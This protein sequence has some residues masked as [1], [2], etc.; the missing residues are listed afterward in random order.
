MRRRCGRMRGNMKEQKNTLRN[1]GRPIKE[2]EI[3]DLDLEESIG[4]GQ[5]TPYEEDDFPE[6][7]P[8]NTASRPM[9][10]RSFRINMHIVFAL[11]FVAII[12]AVILRVSNWGVHIDLE[13]FFKHNEVVYQ[14][15]TL[16]QILPLTAADGTVIRGKKNPTI[17]CLGNAPFADERDSR[18][19][20]ANIIAR[21]SGATVY[22]C[23]VAGSYLAALNPSFDP[24]K[25]PMDAFNFYWLT[26]IICGDSVDHYYTQAKDVLGSALPEAAEETFQTLNSL[27]FNTVDVIAIMYDASDYLEGHGMYNDANATD[28]TQF[29]GNLEAGIAV[30]QDTYPNIRIIVMSPAY[31]YGV[32]KNGEYVSSDIQTYGQDVLSTY[33]IRQCYSASSHSVSFIDNLYGTI[34]EDNASHYL[35]DHLHLN[36]KGRELIAQRFIYALNLFNES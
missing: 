4:D 12:A 19:N 5:D 10:K 1:T 16:D 6:E 25:A 11:V 26:H 2:L 14:D 15:D 30:L 9:E 34:T 8:R 27:D 21:E 7:S 28:I 22:N 3:I 35:K 17:V 36:V 24:D 29:T 18:D 13:E 31:A 32:D 33:V 20:L 23:S